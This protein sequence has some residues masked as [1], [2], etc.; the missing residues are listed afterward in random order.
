MMGMMLW[1]TALCRFFG[2]TT[3]FAL[4]GIQQCRPALSKWTKALYMN[5]IATTGRASP[6]SKW[7][8]AVQRILVDV[9]S[10]PS[11]WE[12]RLRHSSGGLVHVADQAVRRGVLLEQQGHAAAAAAAFHEAAV[13]YQ[14]RLWT[15]DASSA[16]GQDPHPF[17]HVT[18]LSRAEDISAMLVYTSL[19]LA[20]LYYDALNLPSAAIR[21]YEQVLHLDPSKSIMDPPLHSNGEEWSSAIAWDGLGVAREASGAPRSEA[22]MAYRHGWARHP[23]QPRLQFHLAVALDRCSDDTEAKNDA[24]ALFE[25]LRRSADALQACLVDSW[26]YVRWHLRKQLPQVNLYRGTSAMVQFALAAT[27]LRNERALYCEFGVGNGRTMR[28]TRAALAT[29]RETND[30]S[31]PPPMLYGF[32]TFTGLPQAWGDRPVGSYSTGGAIP[33]DLVAER[34]VRFYKGLFRD[35]I[36]EFLEQVEEDSYLAYAHIDCRLY[37]STVDILEMLRG[38]IVPGTILLFSEYIG[39][40]TW[41]NDEFRALRECC[42]RFGWKYEYLA[43]S[44]STKQALVRITDA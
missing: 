44:L 12:E 5:D 6:S 43:F 17:A 4:C 9:P 26:G 39:H 16:R 21:I 34:G 38:T 41:R 10:S 22:T 13:Y 32:D 28:L 11:T 14:C 7:A 30:P 42:K 15:D 20:Y 3:A 18:A 8:D 37:S 33:T 19:S 1:W 27:T 25:Q 40:P 29:W 23:D 36:P 2:I 35:T 31:W 24:S